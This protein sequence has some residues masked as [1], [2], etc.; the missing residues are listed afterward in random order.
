[1]AVPVTPMSSGS[2]AAA[3]GTGSYP[4]P[5]H[6]WSFEHSLSFRPDTRFYPTGGPCNT[7][8]PSGHI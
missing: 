4:T 3:D 1:M 7:I 6:L 5:L 2:H 8:I